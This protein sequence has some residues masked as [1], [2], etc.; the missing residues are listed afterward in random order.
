MEIHNL[1]FEKGASWPV[2][3]EKK[4]HVI[5]IAVSK[6]IARGRRVLLDYENNPS[7][8]H[9]QSLEK[10]WQE[11]Y[12]KEC[13]VDLGSPVRDK[14]P[15]H[16]LREINPESIEWL[17]E[18][19]IDLEGGEPIEVGTA[20]QHFQ[21]GVKIREKG[22]TTLR[23]L[24]AAGEC[25]GGQHGANRPGGNALLDGQVFGKISG[26]AAALEARH[27]SGAR[28]IPPGAQES[29]LRRMRD[30]EGNK[31]GLPATE[32]RRGVQK[33]VSTWAGV[34]RAEKELILGLERLEELKRRGISAD[35]KGLT[36]ALETENI[37]EVAEIVLL[38]ALFRKESRGPHLFFAHFEDLQAV[39]T[40]DPE[41][42]K[43]TV[44]RKV[45]DR[46]KLEPL[47]PADVSCK[48]P[49][50]KPHNG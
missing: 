2:S 50:A 38:A 6:E 20:G 34:V 22:N 36:Y 4:T 1:C 24:Y 16:R 25:A 45:G 3:R 41:W 14:S 18:H 27:N 33:I 11:R 9:F 40:K 21:G 49:E 8:F 5:D 7:G 44:I 30:L 35:G 43:Y 48:H 13:E 23:G 26:H 46:M 29:A 17:K 42:R 15:L 31:S 10:R 32:A 28:S 19:G 12:Q 47:K 39:E 37:V